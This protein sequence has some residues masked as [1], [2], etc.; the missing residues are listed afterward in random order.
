MD[1]EDAFKQV[2]LAYET[3]SDDDRRREYD[4]THGT[5]RMNFFQDVDYEAEEQQ[6][7]GRPADP[8]DIHR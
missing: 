6:G 7:W 2:K 5:R 8:F 3:L 1:A 4:V